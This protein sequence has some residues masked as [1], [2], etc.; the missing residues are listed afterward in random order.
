MAQGIVHPPQKR[1]TPGWLPPT[2]EKLA[3]LLSLGAN[4]DSHGARPI[5]PQLPLA[6]LRLL[7]SVIRNGSPPPEVVPTSRGTIQLEWHRDGVDLE[8]DVRSPDVYRVCYESSTDSWQ[9]ELKADVSPVAAV[10]AQ[11]TDQS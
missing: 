4:W 10:I 9:R 11:L 3:Q 1:D 6:A 5:D 7:A 2:V 8:I